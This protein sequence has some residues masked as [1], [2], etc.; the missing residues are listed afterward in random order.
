MANGQEYAD[1]A[2]P[3]AIMPP[4]TPESFW[5]FYKKEIQQS[6]S[7]SAYQGDGSWTPIAKS[8]AESICQRQ[9][10]LQTGREYFH[11]DV[12]G[13]IGR[14]D[15]DWDL[16]VAFEAENSNDWEDDCA[17]WRPSSVTCG[18]SLHTSYTRIGGP[19]KHWMNVS[20]VTD[21]AS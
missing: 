15:Y 16:R 11:V 5:L 17:N 21:T 18:F 14:S 9:F 7:W 12:I 6:G 3:G 8:A 20:S 13:W 19:K 1:P 10:G 4:L 2:V